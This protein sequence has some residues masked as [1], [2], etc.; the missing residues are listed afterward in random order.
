MSSQSTEQSQEPPDARVFERGD[1]VAAGVA[2]LIALAIY[3]VTLA[4]TV[5]LEQSGAF[6][7]AGQYCG[8]GRVPGYPLWHI[9]AK[10]FI[11]IF[12]FVRYR[13]CPNPAWATNFMSAVFG[14]LSCGM[15]GLLTARLARAVS[16]TS[17]CREKACAVAVAAGIVCATGNAM[18]S[19]SVITET[20][21]LTLFLILM[22]LATSLVWMMR[23]GRACAFAMAAAFGLGLAQSHMVVLL[24][25]ALVLALLLARPRLCLE[26]CIANLLLWVTP[27]LLFNTPYGNEWCLVALEGS[28]VLV[29]LLALLWSS[30]RSTLLGMV[31][32]IAIGVSFY[33]YLPLASE[34]GA[35]MQFGY[36]RTWEGFRHTVMR[37][38]YERIAPSNI[39]SLLFLKQL[40]WYLRL[41]SHQHVLPF[42][43]LALFPLVRI[44]RLRGTC[45]KWWVVFGVA[46]LM[47]SVVLIAG[48]SPKGDIQDSFIQKAKFIPSFAMLSILVGLGLMTALDRLEGLT[49]R[50]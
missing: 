12:S 24:I 46:F 42:V 45:R 17:E 31:L 37:G 32:L 49:T 11:S 10:C 20:H 22:F 9:L 6:A 28:A 19:Q 35:P 18:W 34:G 2:G 39:F 50:E 5:T 15:V 16:R 40:G 27:A 4:P 1:W 21:T 43:L 48:A 23:P 38:Q 41:L 47:F 13:G 8:V 33:A 3:F 26:F 25:P 36:P 7:V 30:D 44:C 29:L 14:A